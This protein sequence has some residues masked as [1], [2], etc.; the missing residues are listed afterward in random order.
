MRDSRIGS[1]LLF[2]SETGKSVTGKCNAYASVTT[3]S[4]RY[5]DLS[6]R[7]FEIL[8]V[9]G[10]GKMPLKYQLATDVRRDVDLLWTTGQATFRVREADIIWFG[11]SILPRMSRDFAIFMEKHLA[12]YYL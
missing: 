12:G 5:S 7:H 8:R 3:S 10:L 4:V 2:R 11:D 6:I 9:A 1:R